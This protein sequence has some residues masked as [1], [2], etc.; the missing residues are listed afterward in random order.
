MGSLSRSIPNP[1]KGTGTEPVVMSTSVNAM[2]EEGGMA[3]IEDAIDKLSK[4]H[5]HHITQYDPTGGVDNARR[6]TGL[7]ETASIND[8]SSGVASRQ[9]SIRI[10]RQVAEDNKGFL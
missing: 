8:F 2:R 3:H 9:V 7:H 5:H 6:L 4:R 1:W 10:P